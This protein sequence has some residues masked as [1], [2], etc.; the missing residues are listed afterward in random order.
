M[1]ASSILMLVISFNLCHVES[2]CRYCVICKLKNTRAIS[3]TSSLIPM[4]S[5]YPA[6]CPGFCSQHAK[7]IA[8]NYDPET[9]NCELQ[10][11]GAEGAPCPFL[12][13]K[14]GSIFSKMNLPGIPCPKVRP[15]QV[16]FSKGRA[17]LQDL[18]DHFDRNFAIWV[19]DNDNPKSY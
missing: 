11:A 2:Q 1:V 16:A 10:E 12:S 14:D 7:C 3:H 6:S 5:I 19:P 18:T 15:I 9:E 17:I 13:T 8:T 4:A